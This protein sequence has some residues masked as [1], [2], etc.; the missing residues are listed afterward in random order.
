MS[1]NHSD[2]VPHAGTVRVGTIAAI[3][4][5]LRTFDIDPADV[6][7]EARLA[8]ELFDDSDNIISYA[9]RGHLLDVCVSRTGCEYFGL[10]IGQQVGLPS[11]GLVGYL[12]QHSQ[13]VDSALHSLVQYFHLHVQ[14]AAVV[15][16]H[17][18]DQAF[19]GYNIYQPLVEGVQQ[20]EDG[21]V[22]IAFNILRKL[23]GRDWK[24][25]QICFAHRAPEKLKPYSRFF[26]APLRFD[27]EN[28]GVF[29]PIRWLKQP[30][31][32]ADQEL[33][34]ILQKQIDQLEAKYSDNFP[35]QVRR[36]LH[37]A[38]ITNHANE[39]QVAALFSMHIRTFHRHLKSYNTSFQKL[40]DQCRFEVA[41]Q[42]LENSE[43][44]LS[45]IADTLGY[46]DTRSFTRAFKRWSDTTPT[47]WRAKQLSE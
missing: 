37:T 38:L 17:E 10:L 15:L 30:V 8:P 47:H 26:R 19:L 6:L 29:F 40:A 12:V 3:P 27:S 7:T 5:I 43:I 14:G 9:A 42:M 46:A 41:Q 35:E 44:K 13:D 18:A 2:S 32:G 11:L 24:P 34:R 31:Q 22:A 20:I 45:Q 25:T 39:E 1:Q 36:V 21:A 33:H 23:C 16:R 4:A 28:N